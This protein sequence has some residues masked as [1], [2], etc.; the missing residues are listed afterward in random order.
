[1][2]KCEQCGAPTR[3]GFIIERDGA[4]H[5]FDSFECAIFAMAPAC[6][7][8]GCRIL[9]HGVAGEGGDC[10]CCDHCAHAHHLALGQPDESTQPPAGAEHLGM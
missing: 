6:A 4:R 8:C 10:Y 3:S 5:L 1:M 7:H 9:G 2:D